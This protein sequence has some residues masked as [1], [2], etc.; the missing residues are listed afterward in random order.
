[1]QPAVTLLNERAYDLLAILLLGQLS[2]LEALHRRVACDPVLESSE[3]S[4]RV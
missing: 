2:Q 4:A 3:A 1:M